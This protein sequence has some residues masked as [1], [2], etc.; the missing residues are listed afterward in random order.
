MSAVIIAALALPQRSPSAA[1]S[2]ASGTTK[3]IYVIR[4]GEKV[5]GDTASGQL[6]HEAQ[7]LSER[8]WARAYHM[9]SIFGPR[10][11]PPFNTPDA[12]FS[13]NYGE[14]LDCR[15]RNGWFRTQAVRCTGLEAMTDARCHNR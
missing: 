9:M 10:P 5:V 3:S 2:L 8:G 13:M 4:H 15:D 12:M 14:P 6:A 11:R 7:C 1:H